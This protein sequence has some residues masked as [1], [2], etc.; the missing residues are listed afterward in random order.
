MPDWRREH[1][2]PGTF[3]NVPQIERP[4][5]LERLIEICRTWQPGQRLHAV[6]SH[7]ALSTAAMSDHTYIETHDPRTRSEAWRGRCTR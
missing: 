6:G 4:T 7:W 5:T 2:M 3:I 1:D